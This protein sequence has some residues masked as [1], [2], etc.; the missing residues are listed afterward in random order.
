MRAAEASRKTRETNAKVRINLDGSGKASIETG[1]P[2]LDY[3]LKILA[4]AS[5]FDLEV[6]IKGDL[7]TGDHHTIE[8]T[9]IVLGEAFSKALGDKP[10]ERI[11]FAIVPVAESTATV[12]VNIG[13]PCFVREFQF[14]FEEIE[15]LQ[16]E[17]ILHFLQTLAYNA[18][19][20]M[21]VCAKGRIDRYTAEAMFS[22]LGMALRSAVKPS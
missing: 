9:A 2:F 14:K 4:G 5:K 7:E 16:G 21:Q 15:D 12:S 6:K 19:L 13:R 20:T 18:K 8:D 11:G 22:A 1:I 3:L 17:N 10:I